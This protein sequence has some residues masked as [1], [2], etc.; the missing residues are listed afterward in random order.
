MRPDGAKCCNLE[1]FRENGSAFLFRWDYTFEDISPPSVIGAA[2]FL[3]FPEF[4]VNSEGKEGLTIDCR[5]LYW[6]L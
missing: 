3:K 2:F 4:E 1:R 5:Q 6:L